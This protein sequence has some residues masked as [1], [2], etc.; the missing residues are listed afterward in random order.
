MSRTLLVILAIAL[1]AGFSL[2]LLT[3]GGLEL[4]ADTIATVQAETLPPDATTV[5]E[6]TVANPE[7]DVTPV[8]IPESASDEGLVAELEGIK[9]AAEIEQSVAAPGPPFL[10]EG[11]VAATSGHPQ[12]PIVQANI[13]G[14]VILPASTFKDYEA[15]YFTYV[16]EGEPIEFFIIKTTT[17]ILRAAFNACGECYLEKQGYSQDGNVMICNFCGRQFSADL[18]NIE[19]GSCSPIPLDRRRLG[20]NQLQISVDDIIR[21]AF[22]F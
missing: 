16:H 18:I 10:G 3:A 17:G 4:D 20:N 5:G 13:E 6:V 2:F 15:E 14:N 9:E 11:L 21:G 8:P 1:A 7:P 19:E 22:Y 12:F